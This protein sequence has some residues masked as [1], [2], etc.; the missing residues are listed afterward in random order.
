MFLYH[1]VLEMEP[2]W[3]TDVVRAKPSRRVPVVL[4]RDEVKQL[5]EPPRESRRLIGLSQAAIA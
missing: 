5:L 3:L 2:E 4:S 1:H